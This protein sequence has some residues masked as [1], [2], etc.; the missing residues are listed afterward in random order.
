MPAGLPLVDRSP[1]ADLRRTA[2][3]GQMGWTMSSGCARMI[4]GMAA[5][6]GSAPPEDGMRPAG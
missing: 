6:I 2:G 4:A 5:Q 1:T 3:E